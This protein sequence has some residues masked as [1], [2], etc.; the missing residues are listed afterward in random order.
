MG[1]FKVGRIIMGMQWMVILIA[2]KSVCGKV[3]NIFRL[4]RRKKRR[5]RRKI[6]LK[7]I[8]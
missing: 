3:L 7:D 8:V 4:R 6:L 5:R 1:R 2:E